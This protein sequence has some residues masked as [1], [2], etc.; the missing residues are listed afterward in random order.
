MDVIN[1][2]MYLEEEK[3]QHTKDVSNHVYQGLF[4]RQIFIQFI[5]ILGLGVEPGK[6][7]SVRTVHPEMYIYFFSIA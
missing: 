1:S 7:K 2:L 6:L 5:N 4:N 3:Y